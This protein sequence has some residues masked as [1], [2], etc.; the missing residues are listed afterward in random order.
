MEESYHH[1]VREIDIQIGKH[2][3]K[4]LEGGSTL[5]MGMEIISDAV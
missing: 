1:K 4:L 3:A 5:Q 2:I